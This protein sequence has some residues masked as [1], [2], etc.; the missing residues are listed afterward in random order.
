ME[1]SWF[2][3]K[4]PFEVILLCFLLFWR[5]FGEIFLFLVLKTCVFLREPETLKVFAG[6]IAVVRNIVGFLEPGESGKGLF[7]V[8]G[9]VV[10]VFDEFASAGEFGGGKQKLSGLGVF[11]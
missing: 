11:V 5:G 7:G 6:R 8:H 2:W 1:R 3:I 10:V 4:I 9:A